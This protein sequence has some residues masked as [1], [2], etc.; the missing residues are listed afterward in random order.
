MS[1]FLVLKVGAL[2]VASG[3]F[4][5]LCAHMEIRAVHARRVRRSS[6]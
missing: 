6:L 1:L 2:L 3:A 5:A 4:G